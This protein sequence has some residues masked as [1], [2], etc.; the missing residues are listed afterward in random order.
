MVTPD[1]PQLESD[2]RWQ[3]VQRIVASPR[4]RRAGQLRAF[5]L[6]VSQRVLAENCRDIPEI[7]I[8]T[9]VL[10]RPADFNSN[11]DNIVRVQ[12]R[13]VRRKLA[14]YF[15]EE[16]ASEPLVL[17]IP[18]GSYIPEFV[19]ATAAPAEETV[20]RTG[21]PGA[22]ALSVTTWRIATGVL[23]AAL[24]CAIVWILWPARSARLARSMQMNPLWSRVFPTGQ[25]TTIVV[26]DTSLVMLQTVLHTHITLKQYLSRDYPA[27]LLERETVPRAQ[28]ILKV[29]ALQ[30]YTGFGDVAV[31]NRLFEIGRQNEAKPAIRYARNLNIRDFKNDNFVLVGS[32]RAIPW[33]DLFERQLQ[34]VPQYDT[35]T[36]EYSI[37][38]RLSGKVFRKINEPDGMVSYAVVSLVPN[39]SGNG[40]VLLLLGLTMEDLE[41]SADILAGRTFPPS[42]CG[43]VDFRNQWFE[44]LIQTRQLAGAPSR[45]QIL[46]CRTLPLGK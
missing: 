4:F 24:I 42:G 10:N 2:P 21:I 25:Q 11:E 30:Q 29:L 41:G 40:A 46:N 12:A 28:E 32:R 43:N 27:N 1:A 18:K 36:G 13:Q 16:G 45:S 6:Y 31:A 9:R 7:E 14:E 37:K 5:L 8:A 39:L 3:L 44:I 26:G 19:P 17:S 23:A 33:D 34:Y 38:D 20:L 35:D 15:E 22:T